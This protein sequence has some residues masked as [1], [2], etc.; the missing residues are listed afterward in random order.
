M[1][2][3]V[4][5][6]VKVNIFIVLALAFIF[7][8]LGKFSFS[9]GIMVAA[10]WSTANFLLTLNLLEMAILKRKANKLLLLLLIKFPLLYLTGFIILVRKLFPAFSLILGLST[11]LVV[12]GVL[13]IWS[14]QASP[15]TNYQI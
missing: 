1:W 4:N 13:S 14:R 8:L 2:G 11:I 6:T 10:I 15:S 3:L 7:A 12:M 5:K 9:A